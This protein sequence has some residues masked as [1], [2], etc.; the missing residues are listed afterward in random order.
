MRQEMVSKDLEPSPLLGLV[1]KTFWCYSTF[2]SHL[3]AAPAK[4]WC[5]ST[6]EHTMHKFILQPTFMLFPLSAMLFPVA[7]LAGA[8]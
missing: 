8:P 6:L 2:Q 7:E 1:L 3:P 4:F 5:C